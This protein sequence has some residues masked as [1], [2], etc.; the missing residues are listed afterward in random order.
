MHPNSVRMSAGRSSLMFTW[1]YRDLEAGQKPRATEEDNDTDGIVSSF[2]AGPQLG[3]GTARGGSSHC[4]LRC[5]CSASTRMAQ[6]PAQRL[7]HYVCR[8]VSNVFS[9]YAT[10]HGRAM[11]GQSA[12][13][14]R[15]I[16]AHPAARWR[17]DVGAVLWPSC[18]LFV[19]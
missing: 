3:A 8:C 19:E 10:G 17:A 11:V 12:Q 9:G 4:D 14:A 6:S 18:S 7:L 2:P 1:G 16:F 15:G 5:D 13:G